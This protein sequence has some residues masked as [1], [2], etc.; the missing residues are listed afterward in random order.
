MSNAKSSNTY[1]IG[2]TLQRNVGE[3]EAE[4]RAQEEKQPERKTHSIAAEKWQRGGE[5]SATA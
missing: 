5:R 4:G 1:H 2:E 3:A